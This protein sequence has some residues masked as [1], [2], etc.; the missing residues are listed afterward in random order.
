MLFGA[1][2]ESGCLILDFLK[3]TNFISRQ[4]V[5]QWVA[6]VKSRGD[7]SLNKPDEISLEICLWNP[8]CVSEEVGH[9]SVCYRRLERVVYKFL[10]Q[11]S[12]LIV[13][14]QV[15]WDY[16]WPKNDLMIMNKTSNDLN[17]NN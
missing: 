1:S 10:W 15:V 8:R 3:A 2:D 11:I 9:A 14:V 12:P 5:V 13:E 4:T 17:L 7:E 6:E 16:A